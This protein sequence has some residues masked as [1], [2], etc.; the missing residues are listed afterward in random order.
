MCNVCARVQKTMSASCGA[1][2]RRRAQSKR[3]RLLSIETAVRE[4]ERWQR[5]ERDTLFVDAVPLRVPET[6]YMRRVF[7]DMVVYVLCND[8]A[9]CTL[10]RL[11]WLALA[12]ALVQQRHFSALCQLMTTR[13]DCR[14]IV[15][16]HYELVREQKPT[17]NLPRMWSLAQQM[18][19]APFGEFYFTVYAL[20]ARG[21]P[22]PAILRILAD[23]HAALGALLGD[24]AQVA[25]EQ[26]ARKRYLART[27]SN[28]VPAVRGA[29]DAL[30]GDDDE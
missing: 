16:E 13:T 6:G 5:G 4:R 15:E 27:F 24:N 14:L 30:F 22:Q 23:S 21:Y 3:I 28:T 12:R 18:R 1:P 8:I 29:F 17:P 20:I 19:A 10:R 26:S 11:E 25:I 2:K 9:F 7:L